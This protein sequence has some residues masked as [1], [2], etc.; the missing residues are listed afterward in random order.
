LLTADIQMTTS[1]LRPQTFAF[2][3]PGTVALSD[4]ALGFTKGA[5]VRDPDGHAV[6]LA[7]K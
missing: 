3:S 2:V 4:A 7:Q 6:M 5:L 1:R